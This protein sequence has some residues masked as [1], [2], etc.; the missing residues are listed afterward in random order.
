V[1]LNIGKS[2]ALAISPWDT[3]VRIIDI[4]YHTEANI[5]GFHITSK[6]DYNH[7]TNTRTDSGCV[8]Q[9]FEFRQKD[10]IRS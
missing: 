5:L 1:K 4:P 10:T 7:G 8:L 2:R 6:L 3:S 9:G